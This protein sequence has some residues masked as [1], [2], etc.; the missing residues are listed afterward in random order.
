[1]FHYIS[2]DKLGFDAAAVPMTPGTMLMHQ[3]GDDMAVVRRQ[4]G[5]L[6]SHVRRLEDENARRQQR[7]YFL[8]PA[9]V[10]FFVYQL[11]KYL[12]SRK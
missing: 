1:V 7:E 6:I 3:S 11:A 5:K 12:M 9:V 2:S 4:L 10:G 8:Y